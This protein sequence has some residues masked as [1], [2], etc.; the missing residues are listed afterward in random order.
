MQGDIVTQLG[1]RDPAILIGCFDR[2]NLIYRIV[3]QVDRDAQALEVIR[4]HP[5]EAVIVYCISRR[6]TE[7]MAAMLQ[8]HGI[9]AAAYHAGLSPDERHRTQE[10]FAEERLDVVVA[11]VAFGMG[12]DRSNVRCVLHAAMPK[13]VEHYQQETGRAGRDG[14][15]A[16][17][18]LLYS[19]ADA[20][21]W[22][23]LV[24]KSAEESPNPE[25]VDR[26]AE[27]AD[28]ADPKSVQFADLP[29]Q[30]PVGVFR[31][32]V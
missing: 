20:M 10:A 15:E 28:Q 14:L 1:L 7:S 3:P 25:A 19:A 26:R 18:V 16:E 21:R 22:E 4:R 27:T 32:V 30:G 23:S 31:P 2:P 29:A 13:S 11:T 9:R 17:C 24:E 6:E 12:I 8:G 5:N